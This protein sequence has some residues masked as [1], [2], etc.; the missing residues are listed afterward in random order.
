E[1]DRI[2][3]EGAGSPAEINLNDRELVNMRVARM[4]NAPVILVAD[5]ERG[6]VFASLVGTLQLLEPDDRQRVIGVVV[7]KFRG[8]LSLLEPGL[9]W[10]ETYTGKP[11]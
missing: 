7:N 1:Y 4:T 8:D 9:D 3:I 2:V 10:F 5:I 6:G 11:V